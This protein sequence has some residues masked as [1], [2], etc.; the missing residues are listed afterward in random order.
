MLAENIR[1]EHQNYM[2]WL[3]GGY[4]HYAVE[5][6]LSNAFAKKGTNPQEYL[7]EPIRITPYTEEEK[8]EQER[9]AIEH[10]FDVLETWKGKE[11]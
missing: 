8:A 2:M 3:Q 10:T 4:F 6:A 9:K 7:K 11:D 1:R 5:V